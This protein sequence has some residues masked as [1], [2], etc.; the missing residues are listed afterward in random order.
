MAHPQPF[1]REQLDRELRD[2]ILD[3]SATIM[4]AL[5]CPLCDCRDVALSAL[6]LAGWEESEF[7]SAASGRA[8]PDA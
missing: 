4:H 6:A 1:D 2:M 7:M 8:L 5:H 3:D